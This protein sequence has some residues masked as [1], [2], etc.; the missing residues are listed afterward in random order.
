MKYEIMN[1]KVEVN[2]D[3]GSDNKTIIKEWIT[4]IMKVLLACV[5]IKTIIIKIEII[6]LLAITIIIIIMMII[7]NSNL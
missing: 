7:N 4:K 2:Y 5:V 1:V 6:Q 3:E